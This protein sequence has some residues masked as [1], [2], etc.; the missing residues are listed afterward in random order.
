MRIVVA[1]TGTEVGKTHVACA[2]AGFLSGTQRVAALKP[3]ESGGVQD[4]RALSAACGMQSEPLYA[5]QEPISPHLAV[6]RE[7]RVIDASAVLDWVARRET[8]T[9][10]AVSIVETAGGLFSPLG[11]GRTNATLAVALAPDV[12]LLVAPDRLGV[13]HDV[14]AT[15]R[16]MRDGWPRVVVA[17]SAP[18]VADPSTASNAVELAALGIAEVAAVFPR[19]SLHAPETEAAAAQLA[20][21]LSEPEAP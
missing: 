13:L 10:C 3:I 16:A 12:L 4:A 20:R 6:S 21:A 18:A 1:G 9:R 17:M 2:L 5:L 8:Q 15:L 19:A 14:T 11:Q 7:G